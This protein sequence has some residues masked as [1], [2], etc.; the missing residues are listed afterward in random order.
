MNRP[1]SVLGMFMEDEGA[2]VTLD[3]D[4]ERFRQVLGHFATGITV[5]TATN[6]GEAVGFSCQAFAALS[7]EPPLVLFCPAR[8]SSTWPRIERAGFFCANVLSADQGHLATLFGRSRPDRFSEVDWKPDSVGSPIIDGVLTWVS[9]QIL[10]VRAIGDH[11]VVI[12]QVRELG[13]VGPQQPLLFY[14]GRYGTSAI[15]A[16]EGP[17]EVVETM[18]AWPKHADWM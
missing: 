15:P 5:I 18:L 7:L 16:T 9:C 14:R 2:R 11:Y 3:P 13:E 12:G 17:P 8:T 10:D 4:P 1:F 6:G